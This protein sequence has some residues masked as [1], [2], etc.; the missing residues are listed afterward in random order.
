M[1][2]NIRNRL[3]LCLPN[4]YIITDEAKKIIK[5][6]KVID[7]VS[8]VESSNDFGEMGPPYDIEMEDLR[9]KG[10][11]FD[12]AGNR[13][14]RELEQP[15]KELSNKYLSQNQTPTLEEAKKIFPALRELYSA[16]MDPAAEVHPRQC[17]YAWHYLTNV[18]A[19]MSATKWIS[20][21]DEI[22]SLVKNILLQASNYPEPISNPECDV[23]F[24]QFPS[25]GLPSPRVEAAKGLIL[26]AWHQAYADSDVLRAIEQLSKDPVAAVR[27]QIASSANVLY[28]TARKLMWKIIEDTCRDE[29]N[30]G[31]LHVLLLGP[32]KALAYAE[33]DHITNITK[34]VFDR[35]VDEHNAGK[36]RGLCAEIF[37]DIYIYHGHVICG[38]VVR[39][40]ITKLTICH[41][42][43]HHVLMRLRKPLTYG[44]ADCDD[45]QANAI[46]GRAFELLSG[47]L[48]SGRESL[49]QIEEKDK[50]I[51]FREWSQS[52]QDKVKAI[53]GLID[54]IGYEVYFASGAYDR[55]HAER[56]GADRTIKPE[57]KRF[58]REASNV[59]NELS[60][61][62]IPNV[63]HNFLETLNFFI[64]LQPDEVF[65]LIGRTIRSG[66]QMGY[67]Y[68]PLAVGL[69]VKLI[70]RYLAEFRSLLNEN[71]EC[72]QVLFEILDIF[73]QAGW[74]D[75][76]RLAY[77]LEEIFR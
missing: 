61:V 64:P 45:P 15:L 31:V 7:V 46:R 3:L 65:I 20:R 63:V 14:I 13:K 33:P 22:G 12:A 28:Q 25:W 19:H 75:A 32:I 59:F 1:S 42:E 62:V 77:R 24:D 76:R 30:H 57:C 4:E 27:F 67:Q 17:D 8:E 29:T 36:L 35:L 5:K 55:E 39:E 66:Q 68:D 38:E 11:P 52:E 70:G 10:V 60:D 37:S 74:P 71:E 51:P 6:I 40:F 54:S 49:L 48:H 18:C 44:P 34:A 21:D 2:E 26:P 9:E 73:V 23:N 47:L 58:Y 43:A 72:R 56:A 16:L 50:S 69:V 53:V 41:D